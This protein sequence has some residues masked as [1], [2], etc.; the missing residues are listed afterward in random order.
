MSTLPM[1]NDNPRVAIN[2][3]LMESE[4][5]KLR[6]ELSKATYDLDMYRGCYFAVQD[7]LSAA[8]GPN[9]ED[10]AGE[11]IAADVHLLAEQR[12]EA[13]A[14]LDRI[15]ELTTWEDG[16]E[17]RED[18]PVDEILDALKAVA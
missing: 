17:Q 12:D 1:S 4:V 6:A 10:G 5:N 13:R 16:G 7:V 11:G 14:A 2:A 8:L 18:I 9:E 3:T 15:R